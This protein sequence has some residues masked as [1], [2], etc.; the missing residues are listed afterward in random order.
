MPLCD[1]ILSS[2]LATHTELVS[3]IMR[4]IY[5]D[6]LVTGSR[7]DNQAYKLYNAWSQVADHYWKLVLSSWGSFWPTPIIISNWRPMLIKRNMS[8]VVTNPS[9]AADCTETF[10]HA[11]DTGREAKTSWWWIQGAWSNL[12]CLIQSICFSLTELA[13]QL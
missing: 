13:K 12:E 8:F 7:S 1:I 2:T 4:S 3:D 6:N 9:D 5:V 10:A 11:S